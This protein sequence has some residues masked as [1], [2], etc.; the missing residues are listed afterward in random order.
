MKILLDTNFILTCA[1]QKI[2][3]ESLVDE[4]FDE[5]IKWI[6]PV[7]VLTELE[8]LS[9]RQ[10]EK[11]KDKD[12]ASVG[13]E[14]LDKMDMENIKL[15]TE[16]VDDGL[17]DYAKKSKCILA[18]LD[19]ELKNRVNCRILIIRGKKNLEIV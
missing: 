14:I 7:E 5:Q 12:A 2:D 17:V 9:K 19:K 13:L 1:K 18:T 15:G 16:H 4:L 6:V 11:V 3:F 8:K 10:G